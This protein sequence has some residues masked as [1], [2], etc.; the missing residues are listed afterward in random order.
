VIIMMVRSR[1]TANRAACGAKR[2]GCGLATLAV[3]VALAEARA[4]LV[5]EPR[6]AS[7]TVSS[8]NVA[9]VEDGNGARVPDA[10]P[11]PA[12]ARRGLLG[13]CA[14]DACFGATCDAWGD[15]CSALEAAG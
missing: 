5:L 8:E 9:A 12:S 7:S 4:A 14:P 11:R 15:D 1:S 2:R 3:L 10:L 13:T 6:R